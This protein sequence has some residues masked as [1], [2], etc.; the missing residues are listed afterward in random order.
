M[1]RHNIASRHA[2]FRHARRAAAHIDYCLFFRACW[3]ALPLPRFCA[4][5]LSPPFADRC[6]A[7]LSVTFEEDT[8]SLRRHASRHA[9]SARPRRYATPPLRYAASITH[10]C[11]A[12]CHHHYAT[13]ISAFEP[14]ASP[15]RRHNSRQPR[16]FLHAV[17]II[18]RLPAL[19][20]HLRHVITMPSRHAESHAG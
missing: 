12:F 17:P 1:P 10:H 16:F 11:R 2:P 13:S 14:P 9:V 19:T 3:E 8:P 15:R 4:V 5:I 7:P 20:P 18:F 6:R